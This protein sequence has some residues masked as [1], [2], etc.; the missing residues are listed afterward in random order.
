MCKTFTQVTFKMFAGFTQNVTAE[1]DV[2][3]SIVGEQLRIKLSAI[4]EPKT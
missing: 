4:V 3:E 1:F 2:S